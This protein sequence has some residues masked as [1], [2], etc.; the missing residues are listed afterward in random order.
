MM[1]GIGGGRTDESS[2]ASEIKIIIIKFRYVFRQ[3]LF[4]VETARRRETRG[5]MK[6]TAFAGRNF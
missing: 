4:A 6:I 5:M 2:L 3:F 1:S